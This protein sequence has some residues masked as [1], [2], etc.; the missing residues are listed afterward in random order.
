MALSVSGSASGP[1][2]GFDAITLNHWL[3]FKYKCHE[4]TPA[5][6]QRLFE[7]IV[8]RARP[9][10]VAIRAYGNIGDR[11]CDGLFAADATIFQVY[12]PDEWKQ[13]ELEAKVE[14]D[15]GGA[16]IHWP[17]MRAWVFVYNVRRGLP[18]DIARL[19]LA[20][21]AGH[22]TIEF[23][24]WSSDR[25]WEMARGLSLQQR[26]EILGAPTGYEHLFF[27]PGATTAEIAG[28]L[29]QSWFVIIQDTMSPVNLAAVT[30]ALAPDQP[31]GAP[32]Y[33]RPVVG[34]PPWMDAARYQQSTVHEAVERSR[35]IVPRFAVFSF[36]QIP[37]AIHLG[38]VLSDR[39]QV[40]C[41]HGPHRFEYS[42]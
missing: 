6:F 32:V 5:E 27:A 13:A 1:P 4:E 2:P 7:N 3:W 33:V 30:E 35:D 20:K 31:F 25:L 15:F 23:D 26:S 24:H 10:F 40:R 38:F 22:P 39:L 36:A 9:E 17:T 18:P 11:K 29:A 42:G 34:P 21:R 28:I 14:E 41:F 12:A 8:K 37:L 19:L 16:L